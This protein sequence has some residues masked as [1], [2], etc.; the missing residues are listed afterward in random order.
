M[1]LANPQLFHPP[2]LLL[3]D[4]FPMC[5]RIT[6]DICSVGRHEGGRKTDAY[7]QVI[8]GV[9]TREEALVAL[10]QVSC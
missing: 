2:T 5:S 7:G 10:D 9:R 8:H 1:E 4:P 3:A 6:N